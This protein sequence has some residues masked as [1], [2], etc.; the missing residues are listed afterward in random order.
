LTEKTRQ[1]SLFA[2]L[3]VIAIWGGFNI[4]GSNDKK[5]ATGVKQPPVSTAPTAPAPNA[6]IPVAEKPFA[7]VDSDY[8]ER[9]RQRPWGRDPFY[10][11]YNPNRPIEISA[12]EVNLHL[13]GILYR[14]IN[15]QALINGQVVKKG[16]VVD[17]YEITEITKE[18]VTVKDG[19]KM[20]HLRV[21]RESS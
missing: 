4:F 16:D 18:Y 17:G 13:L 3:I 9:C 2:L 7:E 21:R 15:A 19:N 6:I 8:I 1:K 5:N 12:E 11:G 10:N 14:E 20:I